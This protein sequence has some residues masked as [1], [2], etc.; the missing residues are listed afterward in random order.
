[1]DEKLVKSVKCFIDATFDEIQLVSHDLDA[2][3]KVTSVAVQ[4]SFNPLPRFAAIGWTAA[5]IKPLTNEKKFSQS[6]S[7]YNAV[8]HTISQTLQARLGPPTAAVLQ[9]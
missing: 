9:A 1:M 3:F 2:T 4:Q 6:H 7:P 5:N 8:T